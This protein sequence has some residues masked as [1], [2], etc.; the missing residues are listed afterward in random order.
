MSVP[1]KNSVALST[2]RFFKRFLNLN[3][4]SDRTFI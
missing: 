3:E 2:H 1:K 4:G